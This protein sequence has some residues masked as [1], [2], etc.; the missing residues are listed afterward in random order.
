MGLFQT[1][2]DS[3]EETLFNSL[4]KKLASLLVLV[5]LSL[6]LLYLVSHQGQQI[7]AA[8]EGAGVGPA[9]I[10]QIDQE[11]GLIRNGVLLTGILTL[12]FTGF[13]IWYFRYLIVRPLNRMISS[14]EEVAN[15]EGDLSRDMPLLTHDEISKLAATYN[16]FLSKQREIIVNIQALTVGI[17][18]ESAR[19]LRNIDASSK[20]T[21]QQTRF[22]QE[23]LDQSN[24]SVARVTEV[25]GETQAIATTTAHN[26]GM[27]QDSYTELLAVT[28][29]INGI[30]NRLGEFSS[31]VSG[32]NERSASIKSV[33]VLIQE[34]SGRT[35]L[36]ALNA[37]I[38]A[39]RAGESGRGFAVVA[40]EVRTLAQK[41][42]QA[43]DDISQNIDAMLKQVGE[44]HSQTLSINQSANV[45]RE[46]VKKASGNFAKLVK[47][48]EA[49]NSSLS[50]IAG[51]V[52]SFALSNAGINER[53]TQI[54]RDSQATD[55]SM[56]AS[57]KATRD[58]SAVAEQ[59]QDNIGRFVLGQGELD[60][61][62]SRAGRCRDRVLQVITELRNAGVNMFDRSYRPIAGTNP[63]QFLTGYTQRLAE[64]AQGA[65]DKLVK[66]TPGGKVA[67]I[68]DTQGYCPVNNS[69]FSKKPTGDPTLD[70]VGSRDKRMFTD[71]SG[72][73]A[74][75]NTRRFLLHTYVRDTGEIM[76]E[77]DL[78]I[79]V[80]GRHWGT[81]RLGFDASVML[82]QNTHGN[83]GP[84]GTR[85]SC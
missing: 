84:A 80:D 11:L 23:V 66:D 7:H 42:R 34:I 65:C 39:A 31:L 48:F 78:P 1:L 5:V 20:S 77:I 64:L 75:G 62:I 40:D 19:S 63:P 57:A 22:A 37:A 24:S 16:R 29:Q 53:V 79:V 2:H 41:V 49:T 59:V 30:S 38:E 54:H 61:A 25:S 12:L 52:E 55:E 71:P 3:V 9:T 67:F 76:T 46:V 35:N 69:W 21:R 56:G 58:L 17:A 27:A 14:L 32:L 4:T 60:A 43:T 68:V 74:A 6:A 8:L 26:L 82:S 50:G 72:M 83:T 47:D 70:L 36:L 73:R 51:H 15:G 81:L 44:T 13:M 28:D 18:V 33:V 10:A 45:T 85:R